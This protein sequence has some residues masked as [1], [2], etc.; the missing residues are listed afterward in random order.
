[1][2][3]TFKV[4]DLSIAATPISFVF[5]VIFHGIAIEKLNFLNITP[6]ATQHI[7]DWIS[8]CYLIL[9]ETGLVLNYN[10]PFAQ[11]IGS[12]CGIEI[13]KP[14]INIPVSY[15]HLDVYKRQGPCA[16][17]GTGDLVFDCAFL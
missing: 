1:M 17:A 4:L 2:L 5:T 16:A 13:N 6:I 3:A 14:L 12:R 11:I 15:T 8:D 9:S 7:L 10:Q